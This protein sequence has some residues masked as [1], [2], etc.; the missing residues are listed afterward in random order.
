MLHLNNYYLWIIAGLSVVGLADA[1][2]SAPYAEKTAF[3]HEETLR[4]EERISASLSATDIAEAEALYLRR[5]GACHSLDANRIGPRH[6]GVFGRQAGS[7]DD[8][9]Y[10]QALERATFSWNEINLDRWLANPE[11]Q[12]P[13]QKMGFR[14]SNPDERQTIIAY[15]KAQS[16]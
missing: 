6:R 4:P 10:S 15:L 14:L 12:V 8:F 3:V 5:C 11:S 2:Y 9:E 16:E 13:G 1:E 7:L